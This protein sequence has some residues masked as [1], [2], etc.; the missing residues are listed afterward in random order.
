MKRAVFLPPSGEYADP[1]ALMDLARAA[2]DS[3]WDGVFIWDHLLRPPS[4]PAEMADPW[5]CLAAMATV[6]ERVLLGPM[7]T[8]LVRRRPQKVA[9]EA[10]TLDRLSGGRLVLGLGLG[11]DTS[12]EL[13]RFGELVDARARG[14]LLDEA[15]DALA[16]LLSGERVVR[17]GR[18]VTVDDVTF[19]PPPV[20]RPRV[21]M[22]FAARG[23][24]LRPVRRAARYDGMFHIETDP[25]GLARKLDVVRAERGSLDGFDVAVEPDGFDAGEWEAAGATWILA[26]LPGG[27]TVADALAVIADPPF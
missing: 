8:P 12:G 16:A 13:S 20:Q 1:R 14:D 6:T 21:P 22:W 26:D 23:D 7:V 3:G 25:D 10:A 18:Y 15:A 2:E 9:R 11:V 24:A 17:R 4:E 19:L 5:I 27:T